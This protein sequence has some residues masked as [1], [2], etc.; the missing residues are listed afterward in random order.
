MRYCGAVLITLGC[1]TGAVLMG[2]LCGRPPH[3]ALRMGLEVSGRPAIVGGP[4]RSC[5]RP[6]ERP[7]PLFGL[8]DD[9]LPEDLPSRDREPKLAYEEARRLLAAADA[10]VLVGG[11]AAAARLR[12][13]AHIG[14]PAVSWLQD[15]A[16]SSFAGEVC[17]G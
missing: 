10:A 13:G 14:S 17:D 11:V 7:V 15:R 5:T 6:R 2:A 8:G 3:R 16:G 1:D 4:A 9:G 12:S